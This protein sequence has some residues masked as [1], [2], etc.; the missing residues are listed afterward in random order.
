MLYVVDGYNWGYGESSY[1]V[2]EAESKKEADTKVLQ[3]LNRLT[4]EEKRAGDF[5]PCEVRM[6]EHGISQNLKHVW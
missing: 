2:V 5:L 6:D 3:K 4:E 1:F